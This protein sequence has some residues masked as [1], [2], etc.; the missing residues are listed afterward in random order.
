[1]MAH[2]RQRCSGTSILYLWTLLE[3]LQLPLLCAIAG[4]I[5]AG[6]SRNYKGERS[7][8]SVLKREWHRTWNRCNGATAGPRR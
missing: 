3:R 8:H 2:L 4:A 5:A 1:M 6:G 7:G